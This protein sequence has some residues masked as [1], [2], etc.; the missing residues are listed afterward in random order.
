MRGRITILRIVYTLLVFVIVARLFYWQ[1]LSRDKLQAI[2]EIQTNSTV[3][4]PSRRGRILASDGFPLVT[5]QPN[6]LLFA[7]LPAI[8]E[9]AQEISEKISP[10]ISPNPEDIGATPSAKIKEEIE[11]NTYYEVLE[12]LTSK[13]LAWVPLQ[14]D[15]SEDKKQA[16]ESLEINGLGFEAGQ[17]R[18]YPEASMSAQLTGFVGLNASGGQKGYFGLEGYYDLELKGKSGFVRQE[19][20]ASGR[21]IV[22]GDYRE[23]GVRDGRD[24]KTHIDR[25]V[26]LLVEKKLEK[27]MQKYGAKS[28]EVTIMDPKTGGII[29][30]ASLPGYEQNKYK[31]FESSLYKIPSITDIYEPG[32][33]FKA[34]VMAMALEEGVIE[35]DTKCDE[36]CDGPVTIGKF[37]IHTALKEYISNQTMMQT[38]EESDNTGMVFVAFKLGKENF[39]KYLE[40]FGLNKPTGIDLEQEEVPIF[41]KKWGD[42]D[43]ATGS[44]GQGLTTTSMHM[45]QAISAFANEGVMMKPHIV[46]EVI[47]TKNQVIKPRVVNQIV[48]KETSEK[49]TKM[50][51]SAV[52]VGLAEWMQPEGYKIA[53]KT[54]TAQVAIS[55][56]YDKDKTIA[57]FIGFAPADD[58]KFAMI[59]KLREPT[60]SPWASATAAPL[61]MEIAQDLF[62]HYGIPPS[63]N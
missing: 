61:W 51:T 58:P 38:L 16:V 24:L 25:G 35:P 48:S 32:S 62:F 13:K 53:G 18:L 44:F 55:G 4:I 45:L 31:Q 17:A 60:S 3:E 57:S 7:Y 21:P 12:K 52:K 56:H 50:L 42:I 37:T 29:A 1:I 14:R 27:G 28:G 22:V 49:I 34:F 26:Q 59:V 9:S 15:L 46:R 54:G 63:N 47:G 11:M 30:M 5:N 40:K 33:T 43:L 2:A 20:D 10:L 23:T 6:Y 36:T 39:V 19:R 8:F 41:R